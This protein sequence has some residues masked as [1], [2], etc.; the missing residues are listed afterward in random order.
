MAPSIYSL[1]DLSTMSIEEARGHLKVV[2][3]DEP[4]SLSGPINIGGKLLLTRE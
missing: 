2:D 4:Q 1:L 3:S